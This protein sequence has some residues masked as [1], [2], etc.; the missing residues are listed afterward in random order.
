MKSG[1]KIFTKS[2][3]N[4]PKSIQNGPPERPRHPCRPWSGQGRVQA[5]CKKKMGALWAPLG[6]SWG[7]LGPV[8]IFFWRA[9]EA[10]WAPQ[11]PPRPPLSRSRTALRGT[12]GFQKRCGDAF[13]D[14]PSKNRNYTFGLRKTYDFEVP[15]GSRRG[16]TGHLW[17]ASWPEVAIRMQIKI[18]MP[19]AMLKSSP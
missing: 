6:G 12:R 16:R 17:H 2:F 1:P 7:P 8:S 15:G 10:T 3:E 9:L 19:M 14:N 4:R 13:D 11:V 5:A 18:T